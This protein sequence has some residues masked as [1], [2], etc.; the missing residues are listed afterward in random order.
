MMKAL[1]LT[2]YFVC[3]GCIAFSQKTVADSLAGLLAVEKKDT[4]KATLLWKIANACNIYNPDTALVLAKEA[5]FISEKNNFTDGKSMA[6]GSLANTF[7]KIGNYP[8]ALEHYFQKLKIEEK[9]DNPVSLASVTMNI[10]IVYAYEEEY[11][12]ALTYYFKA[13]SIITARDVAQWKY[14]IALN[15]G[16]VYNR[17]NKN[18]SAFIYFKKSFEEAVKLQNGDLVGTSMVGLGHSYF[19]EQ[20]YELAKENYR[21][22]LPYLYEA[23]DEELICEAASGLA[24]LYD[25]LRKPDSAGYFARLQLSLAKKDG[26][27]SWELDAASFLTG[28]FR[29]LNNTDSTL[30]YITL[31]QELKDSI[32]SKDRIRQSQI[33]SSNEHIRQIELAESK[34]KAQL[35][36]KQQ[37]QLL[38]IGIFIPAFFLI[39]LLLSRIRI[40]VRL[41]KF[42]GIISLLIFFEYLTLLLHPYVAELTHH[43]PLYEM[44][45]FV[46][47]AAFLIPA[48]HRVEHWFIDKLTQR[49]N[50]YENG[51]VKIKTSRFK[52]KKPSK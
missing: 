47:I 27:L 32:N 18:D 43:T 13:D 49:R 9:R 51:G 14:H 30:A 45:I 5:L 4:A 35:E 16:D 40:P 38:F 33:L 11:A 2:A 12:D 22:A 46:S 23:N 8:K 52:T 7:M 25:T 31:A 28:H 20:R 1:V 37:L 48:H 21:D 19:K 39:T 3:T 6:N 41:I 26:F 17:L 15:L 50:A 24:K 29:R 36:R 44:L 42:M 10:G 34:R